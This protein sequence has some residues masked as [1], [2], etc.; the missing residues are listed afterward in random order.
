MANYRPF[1]LVLNYGVNDPVDEVSTIDEVEFDRASLDG[2]AWEQNPED[3]ILARIEAEQMADQ[4]AR[5]WG[6]WAAAKEAANAARERDKAEATRKHREH[7]EQRQHWRR[8]WEANRLFRRSTIR[9][10]LAQVR[11]EM[12]RSLA[13]T[14]ALPEAEAP[15]PDFRARL[16]RGLRR[17]TQAAPE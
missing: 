5:Y 8:E 11:G 4:A 3:L 14:Q 15:V 1:E 12:E 13:R 2:P 6:A 9:E 7:Q 17:V 16:K 10:R